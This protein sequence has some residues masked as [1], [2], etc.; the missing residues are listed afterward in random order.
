MK[1]RFRIHFHTVWGQTLYII[2]SIPELGSWNASLAKELQPVGNG[3][4][5]LEIEIPENPIS[6]EYRY[7]LSSDNKLVFEEWQRNHKL[8]I[9]DTGRIYVLED[10]WQNRPNNMAFYSS[11]FIQS[12]FAH[13]CD[14]FERVVKSKKKLSIKVL[15]PK[16]KQNH[17][18]ALLGN[19]E[20]LG[21]WQIDKALIMAC[22]TFPEWSA[23]L[24]ASWLSF[25]VEYKFFILNNEDKSLVYW[26]KGENRILAIDPIQEGETHIVSGLQFRND[27]TEWKCAGTVIPVFSLRS[28]NSFGI[29]DFADLKICIDWLKRTSQKILQLLPLNDTTQTHK[30]TDSYPYNAISVYALH[31]LYLNLDL[32]GKLNHPDRANFYRQ[33]QR[34]LNKLNEVNYE[35]VD[36]FKWTFFR[37]LF[38]Q[39]GE[40]VLNSSEFHL[41]FEKN[42]EWLLPYAAYSYLREVNHTSDFRLW[43]DYRQYKR[44]AIENLCKPDK[45]H[46]PEI[47]LY[48]YLQFH[49]HKQLSDAKNYA[50]SKGI[51]LKGDI[52]IGVS[53][54]SIEVWTE[55]QF[56]NRQYQTGAPPDNFSV[57]GQNWGFPT[58]HWQNIEDN[59]FSWW[60]KR[61]LKMSEYFDVYRIDH[62]LGFFRIWEIPE[63]SVQG[64]LGWFNPA[65]PMSV[66]EIENTG[67]HFHL[68]RFTNAHIN[69]KFLPQLFGD[70]TEEV[71]QVYLDR[72]SSHH[73]A[74]KEKFNTQLKIKNYFS[75]K[76]DEKSR[77]IRDGLYAVCNEVLFIKDRLK[78]NH[79]H[80]RISASS[81]FIYSELDNSEK[82]AFDYLY[83]NY[84]YQRHNEFWK[85]EAYK[86]LTPL[87]FCTNMLACGENLGMIPHC[88]PEVMEKLQIF[89]LELERTPKE[90]NVE[91][92]DLQHLPYHSVCTTSTHDMPPLRSWWKED[93]E[94]TQ[95][96]YNEVLKREGKAQKECTPEIC[97][98]II[99]NHLN[100]KSMLAIIPLQ[101][102]LSMDGKRRREKEDEER[103]NIPANPKHYWRYRMHFTLED[104]QNADELNARISR[105]IAASGR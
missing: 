63:N 15:A 89:S 30:W 38:E 55:P 75:G 83:W 102:W 9:T 19:Q 27:F 103:I 95:R 57:T 90:P 52:P 94:K 35:Q 16:V 78:P 34:E 46:Y 1:I 80:P 82:Y 64:L 50:H 45:P 70:Y 24:D 5:L 44:E 74:P 48:Y 98:Q 62:I 20:E 97:E 65:L 105:L 14:K 51:V 96:Y 92:S 77:I 58:Y 36:L 54:T 87:T 101:D 53:Q 13:P 43:N 12:W 91:F 59:D 10:Y 25:P 23:E 6:F 26:E 40:N 18:I 32:M 81:S 73:F 7:F 39:E 69:E 11:A 4:W 88:V 31:P 49:L 76:E 68:E 2:G 42:K 79:F 37:E 28:E 47:A 67:L 22:D 8:T 104:L 41:F 66:E 21:N 71:A 85:E 33:K 29:G 93:P 72:S 100:T 99:E 60:K 86:K 3:N 61:F 56:F 17:S 84:Y